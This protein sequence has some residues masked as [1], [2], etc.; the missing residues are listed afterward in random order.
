VV[1]D[2]GET[3]LDLPLGIVDAALAGMAGALSCAALAR[4]AAGI[5]YRPPPAGGA[6]KFCT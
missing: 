5:D 4:A 1:T 2:Q 6:L 3:N